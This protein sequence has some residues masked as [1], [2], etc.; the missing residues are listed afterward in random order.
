M[1]F[2]DHQRQAVRSLQQNRPPQPAR[3]DAPG[4]HRTRPYAPHGLAFFSPT[5]FIPAGEAP[6]PCRCC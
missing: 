4:G 5:T 6:K 1:P 2:K 3:H